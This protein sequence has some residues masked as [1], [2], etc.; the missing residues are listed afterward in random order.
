MRA[1]IIVGTYLRP[2]E[3]TV[4]DAVARSRGLTRCGFLRRVI[5][6]ELGL[7]PDATVAHRLALAGRRPLDACDGCGRPAVW[8]WRCPCGLGV[9]ACSRKCALKAHARE[10]VSGF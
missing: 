5:L 8:H 3:V 1:K 2:S 7:R 4:L 10:L 9:L 6:K